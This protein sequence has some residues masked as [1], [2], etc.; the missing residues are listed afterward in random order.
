MQKT[1]IA[2]LAGLLD[3]EGCIRIASAYHTN[4][5]KRVALLALLN[6]KKRNYWLQVLLGNSDVKVLKEIQKQWGGN[7]SLR[8]SFRRGKPFANI[9]WNKQKAV[10]LLKALKPYLRIKALECNVALEFTSF[11]NTPEHRGRR[12]TDEDLAIREAFKQKLAA[13]KTC[14]KPQTIADM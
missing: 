7:L 14:N 9:T 13:L 6:T 8:S 12:L 3:G 1:D 4:V 5:K 2:Y 11:L 10:E